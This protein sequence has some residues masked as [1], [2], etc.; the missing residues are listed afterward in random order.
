MVK[1]Q[2]QKT[3]K[4]R[5]ANGLP[6]INH[7]R[8]LAGYLK[9]L[10]NQTAIY[11]TLLFQSKAW[12]TF[13]NTPIPSGATYTSFTFSGN[14][15]VSADSSAGV[16]FSHYQS[17]SS[18]QIFTN[19]S[20]PT[21]NIVTAGSWSN[22]SSGT[23]VVSTTHLP[24]NFI[25][26]DGT[27]TNNPVIIYNT[28]SGTVKALNGAARVTNG[29]SIYGYYSD[30]PNMYSH[31]GSGTYGGEISAADLMLGYIGHA[32]AIELCG[33][34]YYYR[35]SPFVS[36]ALWQDANYNVSSDPDYY[37]GT[38]TTLRMGT[39]LAIPKTTSL[40]SL[41]ISNP[42]PIQQMLYN[43]L[44]Q[45]GAYCID[46]SAYFNNDATYANVC[47]TNDIA[48]LLWDNYANTFI[49]LFAGFQIVT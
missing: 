30:P 46:N 29:G 39:R 38:V 33:V 3:T 40:S 28:D 10:P 6:V 11:N 24:S 25:L 5:I 13:W 43:C 49:S 22:R 35:T 23:T 31:G 27:Q 32:L 14:S 7:T 17:D 9:K 15:E 21:V 1:N 12:P 2:I 44:V 34:K 47:C 42:D 20:D 26:P 19:N 48:R 8:V 4:P 16:H 37:D 36:P 41:G 45:Y 18:Y